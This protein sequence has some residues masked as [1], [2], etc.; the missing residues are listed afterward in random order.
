MANT[1]ELISSVNLTSSASTINFT[2]IPS[3]FTDIV[4]LFSARQTGFADISDGVYIAFNGS[5][6]GFTGKYLQGSGT[7]AA[8]GNL[9]RFI[10]GTPGDSATANTF[11]NTMVYIPNY[12]G[13]TN[14]S[15]SVDYTIENN[16][17]TSY[18]GMVAGL[19]SNTAA[20]TSIALTG[21]Q[22]FT[23]NSNFYL[24][25]VKNA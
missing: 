7:S 20:I 1:F 22:T 15:F 24:Y 11:S 2:S 13:S 23:T 12:A 14:K 4:L 10:G 6:S 17:T 25:G 19:W 9:A 8:S 21:D 3:T 5:T 16:A 18:I